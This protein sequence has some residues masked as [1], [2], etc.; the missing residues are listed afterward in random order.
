MLH[1]Q[2]SSKFTDF[3]TADLFGEYSACGLG[4]VRHRQNFGVSFATKS[5]RVQKS[6]NDEED[7]DEVD[8]DDE[9]GEDVKDD[10]DDR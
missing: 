7:D 5:R 9:D 10:K 3:I 1:V 4:L 6:D 2:T 8:D